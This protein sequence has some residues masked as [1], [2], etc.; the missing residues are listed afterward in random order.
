MLPQ[1]LIFDFNGV[2][3]DD[4][5]V[6]FELFQSLLL[7]RQI[8]LSRERYFERYFV[9]DDA[10]LF[11]QIF[12]DTGRPLPESELRTLCSEKEQAYAAL[13]D[14]RFRYYPGSEALARDAAA[15]VPLAIASGAR[16]AE[17]RRHLRARGL[18]TLFPVVVSIDDVRCGKPDPESYLEAAR[19]LGIDPRGCVAV[20]DSPGGVASAR[21]AGMTTVGVGHSV[22]TARLGADLALETLEGLTW[23]SLTA[24]LTAPGE[25]GDARDAAR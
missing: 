20:E 10:G 3:V 23:R 25:R 6:H 9:F 12:A 1:A 21:A 14:S 8:P 19:R 11:R 5:I 13:P 22:P 24:L 15:S 7:S 2:L 17:I 4:E 16:G 18:A